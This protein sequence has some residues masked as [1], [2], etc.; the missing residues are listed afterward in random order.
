MRNKIF[1][2]QVC[3][4][5]GGASGLGREL[6]KQLAAYGAI[7]VPADINDAGVKQVAAEI[8]Q[9]GGSATAIQVDVTDAKSVQML[10]EG[11][12]AEFGRIDY[13]FNN[14][15]CAI[16]GEIRDLSLE[17]WRRV[18]EIN[19]FGVV[20][21]IHFAYPIM[22]RQRAGHIVNIS[23]IF[24]MAP[25]PLNSPYVASK[26]AV[27]GISHCL[28]AE[29]RGF[30]IDVSV[31]CPGYLKTA[32]IDHMNAV[33]ANSKDV[34]AQIPVKLVLVQRAAQIVLTGVARKRA[35]IAFP[36]YVSFLAFL[37][38][39]LPGL[40]LHLGLRQV[41]RFRGIRHPSSNWKILADMAENSSKFLGGA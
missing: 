24:G 31:V 26:F 8:T 19:L 27:F 41:E 11:T 4:I 23:S 32:M 15:G 34:V 25:V 22:I 35:V 10:V 21:G 5:T 13:L 40:F 16:G 38:R 3:I 28:A 18:I 39:F 37:H 17:A 2:N 14:A 1:S 30:G 29:A 33:N 7:V 9:M 6:A 20:Y 12:A 36:A